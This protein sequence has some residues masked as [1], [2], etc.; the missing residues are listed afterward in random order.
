MNE[1]YIGIRWENSMEVLLLYSQ[2]CC[3]KSCLPSI[4][5]FLFFRYFQ[6]LFN[7][8][9]FLQRRFQPL[10]KKAASPQRYSQPLI[11]KA[12]FPQRYSQPFSKK[13]AFLPKYRYQTFSKYPDSQPHKQFTPTVSYS[14]DFFS[15]I[16]KMTVFL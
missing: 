3:G 7:K 10:I 1:S 16:Y 5:Y 12:A 11:K 14:P 2:L 6:P 15:R 13:Y 9:V 4:L 8:S